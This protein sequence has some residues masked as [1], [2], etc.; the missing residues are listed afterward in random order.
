MADPI[1][2]LQRYFW[3]WIHEAS[4]KFDVTLT[5]Y[6]TSVFVEEVINQKITSS[7]TLHEYSFYGLDVF[8]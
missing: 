4:T 3:S 1:F 7:M 6:F 2:E 8:Q 5:Y